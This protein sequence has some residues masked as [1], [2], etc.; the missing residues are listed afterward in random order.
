MGCGPGP[1]RA[2][3]FFGDHQAQIDRLAEQPGKDL[4]DVAFEGAG[5]DPVAREAALGSQDDNRSFHP[6][7]AYGPQP[8]LE[9]GFGVA[10]LKG[11]QNGGP[12]IVGSV[13][14]TDCNTHVVTASC[15]FLDTTGP[16]GGNRTVPE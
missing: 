10:A 3:R 12:E 2:R 1:A 8:H 7:D 14:L 6:D 9:D 5:G 13:G 4:A 11:P 15:V 16:Y